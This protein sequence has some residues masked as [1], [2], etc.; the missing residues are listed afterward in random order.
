[1]INLIA[2]DKL[3]K[4]GCKWDGSQWVAPELAKDEAQAIKDMFY[5]DMV[6]IEAKLLDDE[7]AMFK[8][9][10]WAYKDAATV[11]GYIVA[12]CSGRDDGAVVMDGVAVI[13]GAFGS[14]GSRKNYHI[15]QRKN[16][17]IRLQVSKASLDIIDEESKKYGYTYKILSDNKPSHE[18]LIAEKQKLEARISEIDFILY[19]Y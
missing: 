13:D 16:T 19:G 7:D 17:T 15:N 1:M 11:G 14:G 8:S 2:N 9:E 6:I 18:Q 12:T 10:R 3:K 5:T 4:L